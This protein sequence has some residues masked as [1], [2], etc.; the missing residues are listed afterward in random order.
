[1]Q[2]NYS[3]HHPIAVITCGV[4]YLSPRCSLT[5]KC[6]ETSVKPSSSVM[7]KS[8]FQHPFN[9]WKKR[10]ATGI[11]DRRDVNVGG[12]RLKFYYDFS[13]KQKID[14]T[15]FHP[16]ILL[17]NKNITF[18]IKRQAFLFSKQKSIIYRPGLQSIYLWLLI[19]YEKLNDVRRSLRVS[20]F[21]VVRRI[22]KK[23]QN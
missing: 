22:K 10:D 17:K 9:W 15:K 12:E 8:L 19:S 7:E 18:P 1:M 3:E 2:L 4:P 20:S 6:V 13:I 14:R 21:V 23:F 5:S 11:S 16:F